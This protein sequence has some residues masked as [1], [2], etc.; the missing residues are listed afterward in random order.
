MTR[1]VSDRFKTITIRLGILD[2]EGMRRKI[3]KD[4]HGNFF[5]IF[6]L[7]FFPI[8]WSVLILNMSVLKLG[9]LPLGS[10]VGF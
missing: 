8:N 3:S 1:Q 5:E 9:D 7:L 6:F 10:Y 4:G 2:L